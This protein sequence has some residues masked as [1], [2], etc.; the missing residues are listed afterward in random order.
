MINMLYGHKTPSIFFIYYNVLQ[1]S[2]LLM[3]LK[4][5]IGDVFG[6]RSCAISELLNWMLFYIYIYILW[7]NRKLDVI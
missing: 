2:V 3:L 6:L 7:M 4:H 5:K 1:N